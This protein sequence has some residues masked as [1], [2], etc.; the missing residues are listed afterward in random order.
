MC[1]LLC[2]L[3]E[4]LVNNYNYM[5]YV[6]VWSGFIM[7]GVFA[8]TLSAALGNLIG[9]SR[10]LQAL[11]KDKLFCKTNTVLVQV[12]FYRASKSKSS[13]IM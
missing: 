10:I 12:S 3:R 5:A 4:L 9:A 8:A 7:L 13:S 6:N 1:D 11:A 2:A